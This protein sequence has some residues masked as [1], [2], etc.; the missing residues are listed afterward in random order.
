VETIVE[1]YSRRMITSDSEDEDKDMNDK[2]GKVQEELGV[3]PTTRKRLLR[4]LSASGSDNEDAAE[5][6]HGVCLKHVSCP[7]QRRRGLKMRRMI[8][9][10]IMKLFRR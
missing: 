1:A 2:D 8:V 5:D 9:L 4:G 3:T 7:M 6:V 10:S